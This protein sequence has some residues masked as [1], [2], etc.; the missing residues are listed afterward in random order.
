MNVT[1]NEP[2]PIVIQFNTNQATCGNANGSVSAIASGGTGALQYIWSNG[3]TTANN[4]NITSGSY[5]V[6]VSDNNGCSASAVQAVSNAGGPAIAMTGV[7]PVSCYGGNDGSATVSVSSGNG[8]FTYQWSP[9]SGSNANASGLAAGNYTV[10]VTD[11]N[12][13]S[14][15]QA[16]TIIEP[17]AITLQNSTTATACNGATGTATVV[18]NGGT[19]AFSFAWNNG[20][21]T[22]QVNT[23]TAG[24]YTVT[25]SDANGCTATS[26][27]SVGTL[28]G[29]SIASVTTSDATCFGNA[30]GSAQVQ[31]GSGTGPFTVNWS[32]GS[33]G[34]A[35]TNLSGG[36]Y[37]V[38]VSDLNGCTALS[39]FII[40]EPAAL[41]LSISNTTMVACFGGNNGSASA[42]ASGGTAPFNYQWSNGAS[43][44]IASGLSA[45]SYTVVLTDD[46]GCTSQQSV[47][48]T[49]PTQL[50]LGVPVATMVSCF[51]GNDGSA[52][53]S[54]SG[55][56]APYLYNWSNGNTTA[57]ASGLIAGGYQVTVTDQAGC[58]TSAQI[59]ITQPAGMVF[60]PA[61]VNNI[62]CFGGSDGQI[63]INISGGASPYSY[64]WSNGVSS[65]TIQN[66]TAGTYT[67]TVT[68]ANGCSQQQ[69]TITSEPAA[70]TLQSS[71]NPI[72]CFGQNSASIA[73]TPSGGVAPYSYN[74]SNGGSTNAV[75][76][77][78][79]GNYSVII[80]DANN[81]TY[82]SSYTITQPAALV[83]AVTSPDT[84]CIG[85]SASLTVLPSGGTPGY[86]YLWSN[87]QNTNTINVS[88]TVTSSFGVV[89][90]DNN[91]CTTQVTNIAVPV[92]PAL[93]LQ[94]TVTDDTLC[95]GES[96]ALSAIAGGGNGG[97]YTYLWNTTNQNINGFPVTPGSSTTY[98]VS[99]SDGC[100]SNQPSAQLLVVVNPL[101]AVSF[102]PIR[103]EGCSPVTVAFVAGVSSSPGAVYSWN[104]GDGNNGGGQTISHTYTEA[105]EY[106]V[107]LYVVDGNGCENGQTVLNAVEVFPLPTAF[108]TSQPQDASILNP[109]VQF[110]NG[111]TGAVLAQWDFGDGSAKNLDWAP[112]H[113]YSDTGRYRVELIVV[114]NKG[115]IDT[116]YNEI[117]IRGETTFWVPNAFTPNDD[118]DNET[119]TG[120]GIGIERAEFYI[121][122]RW[123]KMV[124]E[125]T[126]LEQGWNGTFGNNGDL[127]P[128]GVYVYLFRVHNG[129]PAPLEFTG[130]VSLIR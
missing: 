126:S 44:A 111:S 15:Q 65:A 130:R 24:T 117:V 35:V 107:S 115:C 3:I 116:F 22:S 9:N 87:S 128:E 67:V 25:V 37:S 26:S 50:Q 109:L 46:N 55:G 36:N 82:T 62:S 88:P 91:G 47:T 84:L 73:V 104:F 60:S 120:Y 12:N 49:Q 2:Q 29:P 27:M 11:A 70:L 61:V 108:F 89:I 99:I 48:I 10:I 93:S 13:C 94:L 97:P 112:D 17:T 113:I 72:L 75:Q 19:G 106:D 86:N 100:T 20:A 110:I 83:A 34:I 79:P 103:S 122:D 31:I 52:S 78:P 40:L 1:I 30:N 118:G 102:T 32:N 63:T 125:S 119:F 42:N 8:P 54:A 21:S 81:C 98:H 5:T 77:L 28:N 95:A 74:W 69:V 56:T 101:P 7:S 124:Y 66:I 129:Q 14:A 51:G 123:G 18:A 59:S 23:L 39:N 92:F 76:S 33:T 16:V 96:A 80:T 38:T 71:V 41:N 43:T 121:F 90:T 4:L 58:N 68:D 85:Q 53:I 45:G 114:S 64:L 127:C 105:G 57:S 6:T